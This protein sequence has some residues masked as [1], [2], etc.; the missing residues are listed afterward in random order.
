V[1][2]VRKAFGYRPVEVVRS[3]LAHGRARFSTFARGARWAERPGRRCAA[4]GERLSGGPCRLE[5]ASFETSFNGRLRVRARGAPGWIYRHG[6]V[7]RRMDETAAG[8]TSEFGRPWASLDR[9]PWMDAEHWL[10]P[11][12]STSKLPSLAVRLAK[13]AAASA[14][15]CRVC[16]WLPFQTRLGLERSP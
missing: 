3:C 11:V 10:E 15:A 9:R 4:P 2:R 8:R 14:I 5:R 13:V 12:H 1:P 6:S 16:L 7:R